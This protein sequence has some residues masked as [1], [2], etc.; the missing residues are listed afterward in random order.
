MEASPGGLS[1]YDAA[2]AMGIVFT[3]E[4]V[5]TDREV[6]VN[7]IRLHYLDWGNEDKPPML[8]LHGRTN[9]AHTW[10]FTSLAFHDSFHVMALNQ[11]GHGDSDWS[12][13][14]NYSVDT[15]IPDIEAFVQALDIWSVHLIGHSM[16]GRNALVYASRHPE[17]VRALVLVDSAPEVVRSERT[18]NRMA[19]VSPPGVWTSV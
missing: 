12:P 1:L 9:S 15:H 2:R 7:G 3:T 10:D 4:A 17:R 8:L 11:R 18:T 14:G 16:G 6:H 5:P 13:D 19:P